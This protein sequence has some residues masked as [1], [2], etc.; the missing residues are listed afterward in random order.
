MIIKMYST[1]AS[2]QKLVCPILASGQPYIEEILQIKRN[3]HP[4][5]DNP[6]HYSRI[7]KLV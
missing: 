5:K 7:L 4:R 6:D 1:N 2:D 3:Y